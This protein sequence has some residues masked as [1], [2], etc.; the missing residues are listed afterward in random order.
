M[1]DDL[2]GKRV[3]VTGASTG[4]GAAIAEAYG[5]HGMRVVVNYNASAKE[6]EAVVAAIKA[7]G[8][9]AHA[10]KADLSKTSE[11]E[12]LVAESVKLLGGLDVLVNNAGA[13]V[14]RTPIADIDDEIYDKVLDVNVRSLVM[15]SRAALPALKKSKAASVIHMSSIAARNG[16]GPGAAL[17]ASAKAFVLN[18]TRSMAKEFAPFNIRVNGVAPGVILTPFHERFSTPE[19]LENM[20]KT[21]PMARLGTSEDAVGVFLFL[22]S[23]RMSGYVT[24]QTIELNGGQAMP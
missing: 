9:E 22:A 18:F 15:T 13:M 12:K 1:L 3:L 5:K 24:G 8:G 16:G 17:Y 21:I 6:A 23:E 4:M 19:W 10:V 2:K 20:R 11:C 7:A 14:K